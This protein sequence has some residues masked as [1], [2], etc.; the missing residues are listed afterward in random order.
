MVLRKRK[1][2]KEL[3]T[4]VL[5]EESGASEAEAYVDPSLDPENLHARHQAILVVRREVQ[6]L[7]PTLRVMIQQ[8]YGAECSLEESAKA[9]DISL[10]TAKARLLRGKQK[11]R[12]NLRKR[13]VRDSR[14]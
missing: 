10:S 4:E 7:G 13:G 9:L 2:R 12:L 14:I 3:H 1:N 6:R 11:L 8:Y 5:S